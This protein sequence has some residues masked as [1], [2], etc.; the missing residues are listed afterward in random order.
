MKSKGIGSSSSRPAFLRAQ[1][2]VT[3]IVADAEYGDWYPEIFADTL[4]PN[5]GDKGDVWKGD[6]HE[7]MMMAEGM[8]LGGLAK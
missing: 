7:A 6:Y 8:R 2:F 4:K 1:E 3:G 5:R